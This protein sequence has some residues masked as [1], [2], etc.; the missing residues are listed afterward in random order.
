MEDLFFETS[1]DLLCVL[2]FDGRFRRLNPAWERTLGYTREELMSRPFI[3]W[4]HPDDRERTLRQ[5]AIVRGGGQA[6]GFENRYVCRDGSVRWLHWNAAPRVEAASIFSVARDVTDRKRVEAERDRLVGELRHALAEV[7]ALRAILP[8]CAYCRKIR[9]D[10]HADWVPVETYVGRHTDS[11]F[12][13][14]ICPDCLERE[15]EP[16][17][18]E[19]DLSAEL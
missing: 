6:L 7:R 9:D 17:M 2:G 3:E 5:N 13:H 1:I 16:Q 10:D 12:S 8:A 11:R 4:V 15:V 14:G 19:L 18:R